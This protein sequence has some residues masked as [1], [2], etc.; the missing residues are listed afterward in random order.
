MGVGRES[1]VLGCSAAGYR[2][3][4]HVGGDDSSVLTPLVWGGQR[5][6]GLWA[7]RWAVGIVS[8]LLRSCGR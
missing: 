3:E 5:D 8:V 4:M 7:G 6:A 1:T 2:Y